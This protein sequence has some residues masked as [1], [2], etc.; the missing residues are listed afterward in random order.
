MTVKESVSGFINSHL[1][2][3]F[4]SLGLCDYVRKQLDR[5]FIMDGSIMR[6]L[7]KLR[8]NKLDIKCVDNH[9]SIYKVDTAPQL[10]L[11]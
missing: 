8:C 10:K 4:G 3:E 9:R 6:E 11:F 7:R 2:R 1:D 5:P